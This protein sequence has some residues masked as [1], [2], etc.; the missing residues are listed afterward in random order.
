MKPQN[1]NE[2]NSKVERDHKF[3]QQNQSYL[4]MSNKS[5]PGIVKPINLAT[6]AD[7]RDN[8]HLKKN[9]NIYGRAEFRASK[10]TF[11]RLIP[12]TTSP[13]TSRTPFDSP[14]IRDAFRTGD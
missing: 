1:L 9:M 7:L 14:S 8:N 5:P 10:P 3:S 12:A 2:F 11:L 6:K 13:A 4:E